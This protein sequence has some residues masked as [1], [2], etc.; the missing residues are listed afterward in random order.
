MIFVFGTGEKIHQIGEGQFFCPHCVGE[1]HYHLFQVKEY[2]SV[3]FIKTFPLGEVD[4]VVI[5]SECQGQFK[6]EVLDD[7]L[8]DGLMRNIYQIAMTG[9][10]YQDIMHKMSRLDIGLSEQE[11]QAIVRKFSGYYAQKECEACHRHY[12]ADAKLTSCTACG[13]ILR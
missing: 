6:P 8:E 7:S 9:M 5:C 10:S 4:R 1:R 3:F 11:T 12:L 2:F 13:G